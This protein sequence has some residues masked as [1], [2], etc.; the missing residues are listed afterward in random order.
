[1]ASTTT[2]PRQLQNLIRA[3][4]EN[5][6]FNQAEFAR[7]VG[8]SKQWLTHWFNGR[9]FAREDVLERMFAGAGIALRAGKS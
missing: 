5:H 7:R 3:H 8:V 6:G 9:R 1:M 4:I 2:S